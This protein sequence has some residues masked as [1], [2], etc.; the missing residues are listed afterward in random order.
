[1]LQCRLAPVEVYRWFA[2][3]DLASPAIL[4][5]AG[6][7]RRGRSDIPLQHQERKLNPKAVGVVQQIHDVGAEPN[8][9]TFRCGRH[10]LRWQP[11][12]VGSVVPAFVGLEPLLGRDP[13]NLDLQRAISRPDG[14]AMR[15]DQE[16]MTALREV[17]I[18]NDSIKAHSAAPVARRNSRCR[19]RWHPKRRSG[20]RRNWCP[21]CW[22]H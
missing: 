11:D 7:Q 21:P 2:P 6:F 18:R 15:D 13:L 20:P 12:D 4:R 1:M 16:R 5:H 22:L 10:I 3:G 9:E 8:L 17:R 14:V 19:P